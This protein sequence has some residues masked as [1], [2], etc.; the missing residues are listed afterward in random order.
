[1]REGFALADIAL[2]ALIGLPIWWTGWQ[3]LDAVRDWVIR[4]FRLP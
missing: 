3:I 1:M 2:S 4:R